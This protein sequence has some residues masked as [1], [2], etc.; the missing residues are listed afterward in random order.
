MKKVV[1]L[2]VSAL[3]CFC[4][5]D[6]NRQEPQSEL[7]D[8][9]RERI[10]NILQEA[11]IKPSDKEQINDIFGIADSVTYKVAWGVKNNYAWLAKFQPSGDEI[12]SLEIKNMPTN[13]V[14]SY[15]RANSLEHL[16]GDILFTTVYF[17]NMLGYTE[18]VTAV[19]LAI[20]FSVGKEIKKIDEGEGIISYNHIKKHASHY[21]FVKRTHSSDIYYIYVMDKNYNTLWSRETEDYERGLDFYMDFTMLD[22]ER[23]IFRTSSSDKPLFNIE[24]DYCKIINI[25]DLKLLCGLNRETLPLGNY[26]Y[27]HCYFIDEMTY[28][29]K[30]ILINYSECVWDIVADPITGVRSYVYSDITNHYYKLSA[31]DYT[32]LEHE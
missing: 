21:T 27:Q 12:F 23:M 26:D 17:T 8:G 16:D 5:K 14:Y 28:S 30:V 3:F 24:E 22:S 25:K 6:T 11:G 10:E 32:V 31:D 4:S 15:F 2:L 18:D 13:R 1:L 19:L 7:S 20:D 9:N 29:E